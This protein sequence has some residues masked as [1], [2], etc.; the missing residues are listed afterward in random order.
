MLARNMYFHRGETNTDE[1][2]KAVTA[3]VFNRMGDQKRRWPRTIYGVVYD[4]HERGK[5]C[6]FSWTCDGKSDT[7]GNTA[8]YAHDL[9]LA[10]KWLSEYERDVFKDP[11]SG[12]TWFIYKKDTPPHSWPTLM[13]T[14]TF[15]VYTFY[16]YP[17]VATRLTPVVSQSFLKGSKA[18]VQRAYEGAKA[19]KLIFAETADDVW[20]MK[21]RGVLV[22]AAQGGMYGLSGVSYPFLHPVALH[23]L[24]RLSDQYYR[25]CGEKLVVTSMVR[26]TK[27]QPW[28]ASRFSVHP[29]GI[30]MDFRIPGSA[31]RQ[32][33]ESTLLTLE[34]ANVVEATQERRPPHYHIVVFPTAYESYQKQTAKNN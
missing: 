13:K 30:A 31:C 1:G 24:E 14:G 11:T 29:T 28:N 20:G 18:A 19:E 33:L 2:R 6:D 5:N 15:G 7:P 9:V 26:P 10:R 25:A 17:K 27:K 12:A 34:K 21:K 8:R 32:W 4:G 23:F 3:V 22:D 16:R